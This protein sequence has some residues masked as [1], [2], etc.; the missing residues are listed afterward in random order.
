MANPLAQVEATY[1][2][3]ESNLN[4]LL[5]AAQTQDQRALL[6]ARYEEALDHARIAA[7][8]VGH[9]NLDDREPEFADLSSQLAAVNQ[10]LALSVREVANLGQVLGTVDRALALGTQLLAKSEGLGPGH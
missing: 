5:A 8:R 7:Q 6:L 1:V 10:E 4:A 3:L 9:S 2:T